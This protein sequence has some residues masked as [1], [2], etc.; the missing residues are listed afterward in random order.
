MPNLKMES[1]AE[2]VVAGLQVVFMRTLPPPGR[3]LELTK[4]TNDSA[5][6]HVALPIVDSEM[7]VKARGS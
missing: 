1:R 7:V 3:T 5:N 2:I 4:V 6:L